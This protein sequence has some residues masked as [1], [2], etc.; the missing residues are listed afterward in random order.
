MR[1]ISFIAI[2]SML[3][4][5]MVSCNQEQ[6]KAEAQQK[7]DSLLQAQQDSLLDVFKGELELIQQTVK[8][9]NTNNG[10][11]TLDT[12][13]NAVLS[14]ES[15]INQ[16][17]N[18]DKLLESNQKQLS[19]LYQRMRDSKV[20]NDEL[21]KMLSTMQETLSSRETQ[22]NEL[23][24]MLANKD[25]KIDQILNRVDS[26]RISNIE[27]TEEVIKMD[28]EMHIVHYVVG[29][30]KELK[31]NGIITKEGGLLGLGASKKLDVSQLDLSQ[32]TESDQRDLVS[33]P[34]YSKKAKVITN[35]PESSY[36]F[37]LDSDGKVESLSI[38]NRKSFWAATD[39]LVIEVDN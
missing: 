20:K 35:H 34:L 10:I 37:V 18:L 7:Q 36:T 12:S 28:E 24:T 13:E 32:F 19:D 3:S 33:I 15:I 6:E 17:E 22:I 4:V 14:K 29:E 9:V 1:I 26:M 39:F 31:E 21:E 27:L 25:I 8:Q 30:A 5:A 16:V 23:M 2:I 38:V 11:F